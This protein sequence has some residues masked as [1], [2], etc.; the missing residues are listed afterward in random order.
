MVAELNA[1]PC[2]GGWKPIPVSTFWPKLKLITSLGFRAR[3]P[4]RTAS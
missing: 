4:Q 1:A 2:I 3:V